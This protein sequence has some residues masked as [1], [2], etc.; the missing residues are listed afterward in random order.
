[1]QTLL[2]PI[3]RFSWLARV[4]PVRLP[5]HRPYTPATEYSRIPPHTLRAVPSMI[6]L[7]LAMA[8]AVN[9]AGDVTSG[10]GKGAAL[11]PSRS[12]ARG[13]YLEASEG[14][15][16]EEDDGVKHCDADGECTSGNVWAGYV[17]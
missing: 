2:P 4:S 14:G 15:A 11:V 6:D 13:W 9:E 1:M 8:E 16:L 17:F 5:H 3:F 7:D 10:G 12:S